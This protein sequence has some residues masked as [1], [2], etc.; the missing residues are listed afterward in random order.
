MLSSSELVG[1][2]SCSSV[3][4]G[5]GVDG[6][7]ADCCCLS[8]AG[9][10]VVI[11]LLTTGSSGNFSSTELSSSGGDF[12]SMSLSSCSSFLLALLSSCSSTWS[13]LAGA[14]VVVM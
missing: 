13:S 3:T 2:C 6:A 7:R 12:S 4:T 9:T 5:E 8:D 1:C 11:S 10:A 14:E